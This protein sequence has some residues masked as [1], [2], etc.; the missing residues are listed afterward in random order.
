MIDP[1]TINWIT[2]FTSPVLMKNRAAFDVETLALNSHSPDLPFIS[3][4]RHFVN[5]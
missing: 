3:G 2:S 5:I 4:L 1:V